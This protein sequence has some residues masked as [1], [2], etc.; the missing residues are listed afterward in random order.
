VRVWLF[1][2]GLTI[3]GCISKKPMPLA[4]GGLDIGISFD[5]LNEAAKAGCRWIWDHNPRAK[6][7]W[8]YCGALYQDGDAI[9]VGLPMT[10]EGGSCGSPSGPPHAPSGTKL[11][12]KYHSHRFTSEPSD[13][14]MR[15]AR[16]YPSLGHFLCS[17]SGIVRRFS[18]KGTVILK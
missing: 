5:D 3:A 11:L 13:L 18:A 9:R 7:D 4:T 17:P 6:D 10:E 8:E 2:V 16:K 15:N 14:D 1:A 12:G